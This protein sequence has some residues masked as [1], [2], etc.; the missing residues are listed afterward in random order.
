MASLLRFLRE[1]VSD[2]NAHNIQGFKV[3]LKIK[4]LLHIACLTI[5][6]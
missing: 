3:Y 1:F 5:E 6:K 4:D 2:L